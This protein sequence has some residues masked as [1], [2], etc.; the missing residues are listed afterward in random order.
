MLLSPPALNHI[1]SFRTRT[2]EGKNGAAR[3][4]QFAE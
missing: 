4:S 2:A 3:L 1:F